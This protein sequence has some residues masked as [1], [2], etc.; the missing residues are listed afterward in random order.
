MC[1]WKFEFSSVPTGLDILTD[2]DW[3]W[4][5]QLRRSTSR[6]FDRHGQHL[7]L[8]WCKLQA[9]VALSSGEADLSEEI[10]KGPGVGLGIRHADQ[11]IGTELSLR[12]HCDSAAAP[13]DL[14]RIGVETQA[15]GGPT[16]LGPES[17][18]KE[19]SGG[20]TKRRYERA[21]PCCGRCS[22]SE[23]D[24][25]AEH[26]SGHWGKTLWFL[27]LS[28]SEHVFFSGGICGKR[29]SFTSLPDRVPVGRRCSPYTKMV[30]VW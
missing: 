7:L 14:S 22:A 21:D 27:S 16:W 15:S 13:G 24:G 28:L 2:F 23:A 30:Q 26:E 10:K 5:T 17:G 19:R 3:V 29:C 6:V 18:T 25:T 11:G 12:C 8:H 20:S 1:P 4:C 9:T